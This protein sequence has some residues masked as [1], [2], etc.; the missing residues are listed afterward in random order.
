M[1]VQDVA[2]HEVQTHCLRAEARCVTTS[3]SSEP[4]DP[5]APYQFWV[6]QFADDAFTRRSAASRPCDDGKDGVATELDTLPLP[7][8]AASAPLRSL[9]GERVTTFTGGCDARVVDDI[10]YQLNSQ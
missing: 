6:Y 3:T 8:D 2:N 7:S 9:T 1:T 5:E 4:R 10:E